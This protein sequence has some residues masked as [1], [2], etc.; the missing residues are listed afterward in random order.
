MTTNGLGAHD[1]RYDEAIAHLHLYG[2]ECFN[3]FVNH[4]P[5]AVEALAVL[6]LHDEIMPFVRAYEA[7]L[8][9]NPPLGEPLAE[10]ERLEAL[11]KA[12]LWPRWQATFHHLLA[13]APVRE[14]VAQWLPVLAPGCFASAFHGVLMTAHVLRALHTAINDVRLAELARGL[15]YWAATYQPLPGTPSH[16]DA[17]APLAE[18]IAAIPAGDGYKGGAI[19]AGV[20]TRTHDNPAFA[21][22]IARPRG[23]EPDPLPAI[24]S[25]GARALLGHPEAP[26][27][28]VHAVTGPVAFR[29]LADWIAPADLPRAIDYLWQA[30]AGMLFAFTRTPL[31]GVTAHGAPPDRHRLIEA[32]LATRDE[33][34]I[35]VVEA[36]LREH[37]ISGDDVLLHAAEFGCQRIAAQMSQH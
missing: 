10:H 37:A 31:A 17:G 34:A 28:F 20:A 12:Q 18:L 8:P 14:V 32:A 19:D 2:P 29:T 22:L 7:K 33:H 9:R 6:G 25:A 30:V 15:A 35:K 3:G 26:I 27:V 4:A 21:T 16:A 1:A 13:A 36:A 5:M 24:T 11:G 23:P